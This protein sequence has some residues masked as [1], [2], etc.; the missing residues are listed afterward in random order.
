M[1]GACPAVRTLDLAVRTAIPF[2]AG[3]YLEWNGQQMG[4]LQIPGNP[5]H[6]MG[7]CLDLILFSDPSMSKDKSLDFRMEK[8]LAENI[9]KAFIDLQSV[10]KW[11]E[12]ILQD[13]LFWE[14]E[15]F[16]HY[17]DDRLHFTHIHID[18]M[19]NSLKGLGKTEAEVLAGSPQKDET[20]FY[21]VVVGRLSLINSLF[22]AGTLSS[23]NLA[24]IPKTA[25]PDGSPV[26][27]WNVRV[28]QWRWIYTFSADGTVT[29]RD[30]LNNE[31]GTGTW[32]FEVGK[33]A[34]KWFNSTSTESWSL[35]LKPMK[36]G[37]TT[38]QGKTY[39]VNAVRT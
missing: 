34:F 25:S 37:T 7:V 4:R 6:Q 1:A 11:T 3:T 10:M 22:T 9:V 17:G 24:T 18:W 14:P 27:T 8:A 28:D 32:D 2:L 29:W 5:R 23:I 38:M 13:R 35:P 33:I 31:N 26:G 19:T 16:R 39:D 12:I 36:T 30:P 20:G 15:Y 21:A